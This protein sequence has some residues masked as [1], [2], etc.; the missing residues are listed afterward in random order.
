MSHK[1]KNTHLALLNSFFSAPSRTLK[2]LAPIHVRIRFCDPVFYVHLAM[3]Y[4]RHGE[5]REHKV[6]FTAFLLTAS[7]R[8]LRHVGSVLLQKMPAREVAQI[9][10]FLKLERGNIPRSTR[11]AVKRYL[12]QL[13]VGTGRFD[14]EALVA[15]RALKHLYASLH[16]APSS[17]A[18]AVLFKNQPPPGSPVHALRKLAGTRDPRVQ[19]E[20]ITLFA[21]PYDLAIGALDGLSFEV[22]Y[23]LIE[24][25]NP[26]E[27]HSRF[28]SMKARGYLENDRVHALVEDKLKQYEQEKAAV[29]PSRLD[30]LQAILACPL[31][32]ELP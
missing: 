11:T 14:S 20:L 19:A 13:E 31:P 22:L 7:L 9:V 12:R 6:L 18:D 2:T 8:Q 24:K 17:R 28:A 27:A 30:L 4:D 29:Q 26:E 3:W 25:M 23:A 1:Q 5:V 10:D 16:I 32:T 21:I 15:K